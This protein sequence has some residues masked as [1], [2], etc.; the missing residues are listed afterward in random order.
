MEGAGA[1]GLKSLWRSRTDIPRAKALLL[2][3]DGGAD[4]EGD[5]G[6]GEF[7]DLSTEGDGRLIADH[8]ESVGEVGE[9]GTS[10][11]GDLFREPVS[12]WDSWSDFRRT[13]LGVDRAAR[14]PTSSGTGS[15]AEA[16]VFAADHA[17]EMPDLR[18]ALPTFLM[19]R[20]A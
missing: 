13:R 18:F 14:I 6:D 9:S 19:E 16:A 15:E 4:V 17:S 7:M 3:N 5:C 2:L 11:T 12:I 1:D 8:S 20:K 10:G